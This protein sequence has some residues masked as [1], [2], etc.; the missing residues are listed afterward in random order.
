MLAYVPTAIFW[1]VALA[2]ANGAAV[3]AANMLGMSGYPWREAPFKWQALDV[4]YLVVDVVV[5]VGLVL[6]W[7]IGLIAF[8]V[9]AGTQLVLYTVFR[10][11][12]LDVPERFVS[13]G[14]ASSLNG[15]LI[16][17]IVTV[18]LICLAIWLKGHLAAAQ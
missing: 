11:W 17:H 12:I 7:R 15:L 13:P 4:F 18:V 1:L 5:V 6:G 16:F 8:F 3:H 14:M 9:A 10:N 2:Y